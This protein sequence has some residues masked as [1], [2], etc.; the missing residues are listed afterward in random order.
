MFNEHSIPWRFL[1][2]VESKW[3][4]KLYQHAID[5]IR[6]IWLSEI[7]FE[8]DLFLKEIISFM[9]CVGDYLDGNR[10]MC[11]FRALFII[12]MNNIWFY[13]LLTSIPRYSPHGELLHI[14]GIFFSNPVSRTTKKIRKMRNTLHVESLC[15]LAILYSP[16]NRRFRNPNNIGNRQ[17]SIISFFRWEMATSL[18]IIKESLKLDSLLPPTM[19]IFNFFFR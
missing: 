19:Y 5:V 11:Q 6:P 10:Y 16:G 8:L 15:R 3:N 2:Y 9:G 7:G 14:I 4:R 13:L 18:P 12:S 1:R 17:K